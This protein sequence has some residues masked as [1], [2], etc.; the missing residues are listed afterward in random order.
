LDKRLISTSPAHWAG[1]TSAASSCWRS[2]PLAGCSILDVLCQGWDTTVVAWASRGRQKRCSSLRPAV[3]HVNHLFA[4]DAK[5]MGLPGP[6]SSPARLGPKFRLGLTLPSSQ[7]ERD[8]HAGVA[9]FVGESA[10][11]DRAGENHAAH[12]Q[13]SDGACPGMARP[14]FI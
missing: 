13:S 3:V 14:F 1:L 5:R 9:Q 8:A 4:K 10:I 12:A 2:R 7:L 11:L 6:A